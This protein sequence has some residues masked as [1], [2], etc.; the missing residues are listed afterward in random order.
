MQQNLITKIREYLP[1]I[2][3]NGLSFDIDEHPYENDLDSFTENIQIWSHTILEKAKL[4]IAVSEAKA[5]TTKYGLEPS[6]TSGE[7][8]PTLG[9]FDSDGFTFSGL[10]SFYNS[11]NDN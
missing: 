1:E 10:D 5:L 4:P 8:N 11:N 9:S 2:D 6:D 3:V 7:R